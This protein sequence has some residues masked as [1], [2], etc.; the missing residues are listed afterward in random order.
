MNSTTERPG[1]WDILITFI[2]EG[3]RAWKERD[4]AAG[5]EVERA[6][7]LSSMEAIRF[8]QYLEQRDL[9]E[10]ENVINNILAYRLAPAGLAF[11]EGLPSL[12][13]V[14]AAQTAVIVKAHAPSE[15]VKKKAVTIIREAAIK[16][17][18]ERGID[19][20]VK[21]APTLYN[22]ARTQ[23]PDLPALPM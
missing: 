19:L 22:M 2:R 18:F 8:L 11:A 10:Q 17:A 21:A 13:A 15:E 20:A 14:L 9:I 7:G 12:D 1:Y 4:V 5:A 3:H 6:M 16:M 23:F